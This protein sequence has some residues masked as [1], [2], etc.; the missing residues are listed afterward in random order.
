M[1]DREKPV[2]NRVIW[3][4]YHAYQ[5]KLHLNKMREIR[6][7][8]KLEAPVSFKLMGKA[9]AKKKQQKFEMQAKLER[10][11]LILLS[12]MRRIMTSKQVNNTTPFLKGS[13]N[14]VVRKKELVRIM[15]ENEVLLNRLERRGPIYS[16]DDW[17][18]DHVRKEKQLT[19]M[20]RYPY[21]SHSLPL[22]EQE[23]VLRLVH[24]R[25]TPTSLGG[26]SSSRSQ[27]RMA[28]VSPSLSRASSRPISRA[29][30]ALGFRR[31]VSRG[32][33]S[34]GD[35]GFPLPR[36]RTL[37]PNGMGRRDRRPQSAG[38]SG[39]EMGI[40]MNLGMGMNIDM[41]MGRDIG[42]Y[43]GM[44]GMELEASQRGAGA[45]RGED[46]RLMDEVISNEVGKARSL[47][48]S[49][50]RTRGR[51]GLRA[52]AITGKGT[53]TN[54]NP[55]SMAV[56]AAAAACIFSEKG[57]KVGGI[58]CTLSAYERLK[59]F[60]LEFR[61]LDEGGRSDR[62][63]VRVSFTDLR[64]RFSQRL[65]L[66]EPENT[67]ALVLAILPAL[68]WVEQGPLFSLQIQMDRIGAHVANATSTYNFDEDVND[69]LED[70][71]A[72]HGPLGLG[73]LRL[74]V[75]CERLP[76]AQSKL[77]NL[78]RARMSTS[79]SMSMSREDQDPDPKSDPA[80]YM[81]LVTDADFR[82]VD[83]TEAVP[84]S[85]QPLFQ[86][87]IVTLPFGQMAF[88]H[89]QQE[90]QA[91]GALSSSSSSS[92]SDFSSLSSS[93]A[94]MLAWAGKQIVRFDVCDMVNGQAAEVLGSADLPLS[95]LLTLQAG[96]ELRVKL[97]STW[98]P[99]TGHDGQDQ[100]LASYR[101]QVAALLYVRHSRR[102]YTLLQ[103]AAL[104][105]AGALSFADTDAQLEKE[106][107]EALRKEE[108]ERRLAEKHLA[109]EEKART[110]AASPK[111]TPKAPRSSASAGADGDANRREKLQQQFLERQKSRADAYWKKKKDA[112][113][114]K[115]AKSETKSD[116]RRKRVANPSSGALVTTA[117]AVI[118]TQAVPSL[119]PSQPQESFSAISAPEKGEEGVCSS[120]GAAADAQGKD[121]QH[122]EKA[123]SEGVAEV[124]VATVAAA[125]TS[126]IADTDASP[127]VVADTTATPAAAPVPGVGIDA[128]AAVVAAPESL[129]EGQAASSKAVA[130]DEE[131]K[132]L[133]MNQSGHSVDDLSSS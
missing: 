43:D 11:N 59:P 22:E 125:N 67:T 100:P 128:P 27:S 132:E 114:A 85:S 89:Y 118:A 3:E 2:A 131:Q 52:T 54:T 45:G 1:G 79:M 46:Y 86:K 120:S 97:E 36:A 83:K 33:A 10:D 105:H 127:A 110:A 40:D 50:S 103:K 26:A 107:E 124:P 65:D 66:L 7:V 30:T 112:S 104:I 76:P 53:N 13:L 5:Y 60:C 69:D 35:S 38:H 126:I 9:N 98:V 82:F 58:K 74:Q 18:K 32:S 68:Y 119:A 47:A 92:S 94:T 88:Q 102:G 121:T 56:D 133:G 101:K 99:P 115:E 17:E 106:V 8:L 78:S 16:V 96:A 49:Q 70:H 23:N 25:S 19:T 81:W 4:Q 20:G 93:E 116:M 80:V 90:H 91:T 29:N 34:E 42:G 51:A 71:S 130:R 95:Q 75:R 84:N 48:Q 129:A 109:D 57:V 108:A 122:E 64:T 21:L 44:H 73:K 62:S 6:P 12:R 72:A 37:T 14:K 39:M 77:T 31:P 15:G 117:A 111:R 24:R 113:Q 123:V 55:N 61:A 63:P 28:S 41:S 87:E